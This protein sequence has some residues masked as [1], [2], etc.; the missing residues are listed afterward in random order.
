MKTELMSTDSNVAIILQVDAALPC[1]DLQQSDHALNAG[2]RQPNLCLL[3]R[4]FLRLFY[5]HA[6]F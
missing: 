1:P 5:V 2:M 6:H 4:P 3:S